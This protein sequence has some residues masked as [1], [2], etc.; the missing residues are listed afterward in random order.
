MLPDPRALT[1][2]DRDRCGAQPAHVGGSMMILRAA[3][4]VGLAIG[5]LAAPLAAEGQQAG[6]VPRIGILAGASS[7]Y[8]LSVLDRFRQELGKLGWIEGQTVTVLELCSAEGR[9]ERLPA[10]AAEVLKADPRVIVAF[11]APATRALQQATTTIPIVN[12][13]SNPLSHSRQQ[14]VP[15]LNRRGQ[16]GIPSS[17][18]SWPASRSPGAM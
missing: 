1:F 2:R 15:G 10:V 12:L 14:R 7:P 8:V 4:T 6:K 18:G 3:L 17:T 13:A 11:S 5:L 9:N 16:S